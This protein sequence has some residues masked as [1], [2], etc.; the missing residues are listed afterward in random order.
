VVV[1]LFAQIK[2]AQD[3][4]NARTVGHVFEQIVDQL[5]QRVAGSDQPSAEDLLCVKREDLER[6]LVRRG[7]VTE[8]M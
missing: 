8:R 6:V 3:F 4:G 1:D 2:L 7:L 5:D